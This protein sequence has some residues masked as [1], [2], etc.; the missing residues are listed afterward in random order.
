MGGRYYINNY[1]RSLKEIMIKLFFL[2]IVK[3]YIIRF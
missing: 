2:V 1:G 3:F